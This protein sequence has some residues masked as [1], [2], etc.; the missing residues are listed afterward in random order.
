MDVLIVL[1]LTEQNS[2]GWRCDERL[3]MSDLICHQV[4]NLSINAEL[5]DYG[6]LLIAQSFDC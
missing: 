3:I 4:L 1:V 5:A 6:R 2:C